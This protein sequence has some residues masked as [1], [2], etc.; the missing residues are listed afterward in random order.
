M[1]NSD[2]L[3]AIDTTVGQLTSAIAAYNAAVSNVSNLQASLATAQAALNA[4]LADTTTSPSTLSARIPGEQALVTVYQTQ[5]T[6]AQAAA[7][8]ALET[9]YLTGI[10]CGYAAGSIARQWRAYQVALDRTA[11]YNFINPL[12]LTF[13]DTSV[14]SVLAASAAVSNIDP[15]IERFRIFRPDIV[16]AAYQDILNLSSN[17]TALKTAVNAIS[18]LTLTTPV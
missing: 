3:A 13:G 16:P 9:V 11:I 17:W 8:A 15:F 1:A 6:A 2:I 10:A 12:K 4:D 5:I 14:N 7:K 18:G